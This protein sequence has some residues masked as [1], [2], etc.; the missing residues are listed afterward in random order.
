LCVAQISKASSTKS[1][2]LT[3]IFF[4]F[5]LVVLSITEVSSISDNDHAASILDSSDRGL[6]TFIDKYNITFQNAVYVSGALRT[7][8]DLNAGDEAAS[9]RFEVF[10]APENADPT[11]DPILP[12]TVIEAS[13]STTLLLGADCHAK[14]LL[15]TRV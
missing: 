1:R 15:L 10:T 11:G 14:L 2:I 8:F 7:I 4:T 5:A 3:N 12:A 13:F 9:G 6:Q